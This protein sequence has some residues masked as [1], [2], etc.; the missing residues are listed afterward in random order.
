[1]ENQPWELALLGLSKAS[2]SGTIQGVPHST[3]RDWDLRY[4]VGSAA[5]PGMADEGL[6]RPDVVLV[7]GRAASDALI[8]N[9]HRPD[10]LQPVEALR[11]IVSSQTADFPFTDNESEVVGL[12][13][14][15]EYDARL[16][17]TQIEL[18]NK[19]VEAR[20]ASVRITYRPHPASP[21]PPATLD[22][23]IRLSASSRIAV[24]LAENDLAFCSNVTSAAVDALLAGVPVIVFRDGSVLDGQIA[25][26]Q[27]NTSVTNAQD[28][29][30]AVDRFI[31]H[32]SGEHARLDEV[33][34][35]DAGLPRWARVLSSLGGGV[36]T[37]APL[38]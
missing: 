35:L 32:G 4:A 11:Y 20:S 37:L 7:N 31:T 19:L 15:G 14:L 25:R 33:F 18:L 22:E 17:T 8:L 16:A 3:V 12:L 1:M 13:A 6:P 23:R 34:N 27:G 10:Q 28:L 36:V 26:A 29:I 2:G 38:S 5:T 21:A 30:D 9:G 24:D